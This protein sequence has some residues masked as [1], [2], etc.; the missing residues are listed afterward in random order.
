MIKKL[1]LFC[2]LILITKVSY[3]QRIRDVFLSEKFYFS[4]TTSYD[5]VFKT[6]GNGLQATISNFKVGYDINNNISQYMFGYGINTK[7]IRIVPHF[8]VYPFYNYSTYGIDLNIDF[9][10]L[11]FNISM[12][13][14]N[15]FA[16]GI[17][18]G[19]SDRHQNPEKY[20]KVKKIKK[21]K[22]I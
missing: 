16:V 21:Y 22:H 8:I 2:L 19:F 6:Y 14:D 4:V 20:V 17:G 18:F 10:F 9:S 15:K 11:N 5:N 7:Y 1:S 12:S 3:S 13:K